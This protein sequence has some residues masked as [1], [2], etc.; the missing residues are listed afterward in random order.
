MNDSTPVDLKETA[1]LTTRL[2]RMPLTR[3]NVIISILLLTVWMCEAFDMGIVSAVLVFV[4]DLWQLTPT[5]QS[6]LGISATVGVA[7]GALIAGRMMDLYGRKK[8]LVIGVAIFS[9]FTL[10]CAAFPDKYW[11]IGC[12]F[13][14]GLAVGAVYPIPYL[15]ISEL[16]GKK[17]RGTVIGICMGFMIIFYAMP[18]LVGAWVLANF[19]LEVAWRIPFLIGGVPLILVLFLIKWVPESPRWNL[20]K[21]RVGEARALVEKMEDEA[22]IAYDTDL[23]DP[24]IMKS[25]EHSHDA[26]S[27]G[28]GGISAVLSPPYRSRWIIGFLAGAGAT[29]TAYVLMVYAPMIFASVVGPAAAFKFTAALLISGFFGAIFVERMA[30]SLGRKITFTIYSLLAASGFIIVAHHTSVTMLVV[31]GIIG[32]IFGTGVTPFCKTYWAEQFPTHLRGAGV[33]LMESAVRAF[34]GILAA[35]LIPFVFASGGVKAVFWMVAATILVGL[36]PF[37]IWGRETAGLSMEEA[38]QVSIVSETPAEASA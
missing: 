13:L 34:G 24:V 18:S 23:V 35:S 22:G 30:T 19:P 21:G 12:R 1:N 16:V 11:I 20:E 32:G 10:A 15:L 38:S 27:N 28:I 14:A 36:V 6:L 8:I 5:D 29:V 4:K 17:W 3:T 26:T 2:D 9:I 37:L 31:G 7:I 25:L 33:G